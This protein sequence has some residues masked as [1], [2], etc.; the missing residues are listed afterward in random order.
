MLLAADIGNSQT[1]LGVFRD[2]RLLRQ[3]RFATEA[4]RT[5]DELAVLVGGLVRLHGADLEEVKAFA[6]CSVV[7]RL[8]REY[9][10]LCTR[11]LGVE[12]LIVG[13]GVK[14]GMPI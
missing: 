6:L 13:P 12:P 5:G 9:Q 8:N 4:Q 1:V 7:P 10:A 14:T 11:Y 3:W 2:G